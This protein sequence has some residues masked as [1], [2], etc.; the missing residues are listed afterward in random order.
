MDPEH[1]EWSRRTFGGLADGG[2][3]GIPRSGLVF[4]RK[5]DAL[6]LTAMMPH[7]PAMPL[8]P[9]QLRRYQAKDYADIKRH[10]E[11]AG[12]AVRRELKG[13]RPRE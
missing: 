8:S 5:G 9:H 2:M 6:V 4:T 10:F 1:I 3:W 12:V 7:D 11:A 13:K